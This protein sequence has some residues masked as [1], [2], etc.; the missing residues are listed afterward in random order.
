MS[1][2]HAAPFRQRGI[3]IITALLVSALVAA[4]AMALATRTSLWMNQVQ[5]RQDFASA[6][7]IAFGAIE[8][9]RLTLR[10]DGR[11]N[12]VDHLQEAWAIPIP[13]INAEEGKVGGRV[14]ELQ[15]FYNL[16]NLVRNGQ[17]DAAALK[18]FERLLAALGL[19]PA[20]AGRL[21]MRLK[22]EIDLRKKAGEA[23]VFP[24]ADMASLGE[25]AGFDLPMLERLQEFAVVLPETTSVNVNFAGPEVLMAVIPDLS[26]A[27]AIR[28]VSERSGKYYRTLGEFTDALPDG[29]RGKFPADSCAVQSRY[30]LAEAD[31]WFGR[32]QLRYQALLAR[33]GGSS[34]EVVWMRRSYG[35]V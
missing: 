35:G 11:N 32:V 4:L 20:L 24:F 1:R 19:N 13:A 6:Q 8:L 34:P 33:T 28:L 31:A 16:A 2:N 21:E 27:D 5:N 26:S 17:V 9:A 18:G 25:I 3:A 15:G 14:I 22:Q 12:Q 30:F 29:V 23:A 7:V 10:D